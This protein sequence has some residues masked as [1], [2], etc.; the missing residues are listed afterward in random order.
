MPR[1]NF[2]A[3]EVFTA[4]DANLFRQ[5]GD[6]VDDDELPARL[7]EAELIALIAEQA[8]TRGQADATFA[9]AQDSLSGQY[10]ALKV[11]ART[12]P[13][14]A[15][16]GWVAG[17]TWAS[18][19]VSA[20]DSTY[21]GPFITG[22]TD[23]AGTASS[24]TKAAGL[25]P[26][27][28]AGKVLAVP[29]RV[30]G[31]DKLANIEVYL[32]SDASLTANWNRWDLPTPY[33]AEGEWVNVYMSLNGGNITGTGIG[34]AVQTIRFRVV[35][36]GTVTV[37]FGEPEIFA[38]ST[39][40]PH[41]VVSFSFDDCYDEAWTI[42]LPAMRAH[43]MR[44]TIF[45]VI[46]RVGWTNRL[47]LQQLQAFE[48]VHGWEVGAHSTTMAKHDARWDTMTAAEQKQEM[49]DIKR[50]QVLNGLRSETVAYPGGRWGNGVVDQV[51]QYFRAAR[52]TANRQDPV[53]PPDKHRLSSILLN[54]GRTLASMKSLI[55]NVYDRGLWL[56][57]CVHTLGE[58][59]GDYDWP[60]SDF[61]ELV[62]YIASKPIPGVPIGDVIADLTTAT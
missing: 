41:G 33:G 32:S 26:F 8:Y 45:P 12:Q 35:G 57:I 43:G 60:V 52:T 55:D 28:P 25:S 30:T 20:T 1:K 54:T 61:L 53:P 2:I 62:A 58:G 37:A 48:R 14:T 11:P 18:S 29:V 23:A 17:S 56:N 42:A 4:N 13:G 34:T 7:S 59:S 27:N 19:S 21:P 36:T 44:G 22:T 49:E 46:D 6:V 3:G 9:T 50:W 39:V 47:T 51:R 10:P 5:V 40:Y 16:S 31:K 15:G 24:F 38:A